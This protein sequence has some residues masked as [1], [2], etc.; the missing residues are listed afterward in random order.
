MWHV[1]RL[2]PHARPPREGRRRGACQGGVRPLRTSRGPLP[3]GGESEGVPPQGSSGGAGAGRRQLWAC[4]PAGCVCTCSGAR[5]EGRLAGRRLSPPPA[6]QGARGAQREL[7]SRAAC[8]PRERRPALINAQRRC[9][10][11]LLDIC[12]SLQPSAALAPGP[13]PRARAKPALG[14]PRPKVGCAWP[15]GVLGEPAVGGGGCFLNPGPGPSSQGACGGAP[16][17]LFVIGDSMYFL[18]YSQPPTYLNTPPPTPW[19]MPFSFP[20]CDAEA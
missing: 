11:L 4:A 13:L 15:P 14:R 8:A 3:G 17:L 18:Y 20:T 7:G 12:L 6:L 16:G 5:R 9:V 10:Y 1:H 19:M 2:R